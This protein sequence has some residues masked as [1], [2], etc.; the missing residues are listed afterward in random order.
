MTP[1]LPGGRSFL[2]ASE[3]VTES[4]PAFRS[5]TVGVLVETGS[6]DDPPARKGPAHFVEHILVRKGKDILATLDSLGGW[7]EAYTERDCTVYYARVIEHY[8]ST[9]FDA[10]AQ[11]I[12]ERHITEEDCA[13]EKGVV[14]SEIEMY[15]EDYSQISQQAL[16]ESM[17]SGH[18]LGSPII[19]RAHLIGSVEPPDVVKFLANN[20]RPLI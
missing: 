12:N 20:L 9:A 13:Q 1:H 7:F 15:Q 2:M 5:I 8:V 17:W 11:L 18:P 10:L 4:S 6:K 14:L 16:I 3:L 19:G